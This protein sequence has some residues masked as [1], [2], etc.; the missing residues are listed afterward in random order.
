[1]T[2]LTYIKCR[3]GTSIEICVAYKQIKFFRTGAFET[4]LT[5]CYWEINFF[6]VYFKKLLHKTIGCQNY[7]KVNAEKLYKLDQESAK[8]IF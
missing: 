5:D 4:D 6:N 1:M 7:K 3:T 8:E 2:S